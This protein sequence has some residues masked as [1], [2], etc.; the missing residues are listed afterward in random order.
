MDEIAYVIVLIDENENAIEDLAERGTFK[1]ALNCVRTEPKYKNL[2]I[3]IYEDFRNEL[4]VYD[5]N[6]LYTRVRGNEVF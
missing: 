3:A 6:V 4:G 1:D 2:N 5:S